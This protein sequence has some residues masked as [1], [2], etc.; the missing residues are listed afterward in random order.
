MVVFV[1]KGQ[2][3]IVFGNVEISGNFVKSFRVKFEHDTK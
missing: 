1:L 3:M 2:A